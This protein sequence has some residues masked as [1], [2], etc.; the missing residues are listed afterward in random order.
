MLIVEGFLSF[1]GLR[2]FSYSA[3]KL[4][5][6][7]YISIKNFYSINNFVK[8]YWSKSFSTF[9]RDMYVTS[10]YFRSLIRYRHCTE[11]ILYTVYIYIVLSF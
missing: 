10:V 8:N 6:N 2:S 3:A 11:F 5:N 1:S 4:Y 9:L 7:L